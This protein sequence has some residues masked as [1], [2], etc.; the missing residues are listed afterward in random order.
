MKEPLTT[1]PAAAAP[2]GTYDQVGRARADLNGCPW[3]DVKAM[4]REAGLRPTRQRMALGWL[5][6]AKGGRHVSAEMLYEEA[7]QA[8]VPV[9]LATVYNTLHQFT[10]AGLLRQ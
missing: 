9:S 4:L 2:N 7:V 5:L 3:H 10:E 1:R 8:R 6:F